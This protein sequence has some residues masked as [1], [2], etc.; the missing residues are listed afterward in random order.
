MSNE[1]PSD[2]SGG[3]PHDEWILEIAE[4]AVCTD[5][6]MYGNPDELGTHL[7]LAEEWN[8]GPADLDDVLAKMREIG[9][10]DWD[11]VPD[12]SERVRV[13]LLNRGEAA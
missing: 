13:R 4:S 8:L 2:E 11:D 5:G 6:W 10:P 1:E 7:F 9:N 3:T 12:G